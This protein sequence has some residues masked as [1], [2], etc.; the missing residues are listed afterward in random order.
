[1][2]PCLNPCGKLV[3]AGNNGRSDHRVFRYSMGSNG[4]CGGGIAAAAASSSSISM[5]KVSAISLGFQALS[6]AIL[7]T[8]RLEG[9]RH[10]QSTRRGVW[11]RHAEEGRKN[12]GDTRLTG[13]E[14]APSLLFGSKGR[15]LPI[16]PHKITLCQVLRMLTNDNDCHQAVSFLSYNAVIYASNAVKEI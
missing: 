9:G 8:R 3:M 12:K 5:P 6:M 7:A 1:M 14:K 4:V 15:V 2:F 16:E 11:S 13:Y 10:T